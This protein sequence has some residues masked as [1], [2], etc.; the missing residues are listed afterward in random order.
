MCSDEAENAVK[1]F[2]IHARAVDYEKAA[3]FIEVWLH[4]RRLPLAQ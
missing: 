4:H 2:A 3:V 1:T